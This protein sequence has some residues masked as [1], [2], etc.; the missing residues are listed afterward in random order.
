[1]RH[2]ESLD[3]HQHHAF[4]QHLVMFE[5]MQQ[6]RRHQVGIGG[7]EDRRAGHALG[8]VGPDALEEDVQGHG[9]LR[10]PRRQQVAPLH[11]GR[12]DDEDERGNRQREPAAF[13][14]FEQI[15]GEEQQVDKQEK[16]EQQRR[17]HRIPLEYAH[18]VDKRQNGGERHGAGDGDAVGGAEIVR[19]AETQHQHDHSHQ[20]RQVDAR[21][22]DL[23]DLVFRGMA[24]LQPRQITQ[25]HRLARHRE[26]A[27]DHRLRGDHRRASRQHHHRV[28]RPTR[29][30]QIERV[31]QR[32]GRSQQ[33]RAL[34]EIVQHQRR[35]DEGEPV[36]LDGT[37][38]EMAHVGVKRLDPGNGQD[39]GTEQDESL[40]RMAE[41]QPDA[42]KRVERQQD[43][44]VAQDFEHA[45]EPDDQKPHHHH[46]AEQA[47]DQRG[48]APLHGEQHE[49]QGEGD[50]DD[51]GVEKRRRHLEAFD[52]A[53]HGNGGGDDAVAVEQRRAQQARRQ[54]PPAQPVV[55]AHGAER[56]RG[57]G[58]YSA[59]AAVI[60]A[61]D[62]RDVFEGDDGD[63]RPGDQRQYA[64]DVVRRD[65]AQAQNALLHCV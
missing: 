34:A 45:Q 44:R 8:V 41:Q 51:I 48:A 28:K 4:V 62:D 16:P 42:V 5:I 32:L 50:R 23:A 18:G 43:R 31:L 38:S 35:K 27:R 26:G 63:Q 2:V 9:G 19:A 52:G 30:Q 47:A 64:V 25:L 11:P 61:H 54:D 3:L 53:Q 13:D 39:H 22:V 20:Q 21:H 15:G 49:Q 17:A 46:R 37:A 56:Q 10:P 57:Q 59:L 60:G 7:H 40:E 12:H 65:A 14:E 6:R 24:D 1:M 58:Q 36:N 55:A 33:Q 29:R